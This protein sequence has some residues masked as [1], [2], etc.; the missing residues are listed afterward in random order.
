MRETTDDFRTSPVPPLHP[1]RFAR[2]SWQLTKDVVKEYSKDGVGD[3]AAAIT[4]W[5]IL[6]IPA[7]ALSLL[8][9]LTSL[10]AVFGESA[11]E[12]FRAEVTGFLDRTFTPN[13]T[14]ND[15]VDELLTTSNAGVATV[16]T[17]IA[18]FTASRAFAGLVRALDVAYEVPRGRPFWWGRIVGIGLALGTILLVVGAST[19]L[20]VLP[21][22]PGARVLGYLTLPVVLTIMVLWA[23]TLFHFGP[24]HKTPWRFDVPGAIF[25]VIG[26]VI[27]TQL[28]AIYVRSTA[29][30]NELRT[31]VG[32]VLL[33]LTLLYL[34]C[35]I[36]LV[37]AEINDV[38]AKRSGVIEELPPV[39]DRA[40]DIYNRLR[41]RVEG[42][43]PGD[44]HRN[45]SDGRDDSDDDGDD[46]DHAG[47]IGDDDRVP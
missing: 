31:T 12:R 13:A 44:E 17:L 30:A 25:T 9:T 22:L 19:Y 5:T 33:A 28:F 43:E 4:F 35:V 18:L 24:H 10:D 7:A 21:S 16:A 14:I 42:D 32:T 39:T 38:I 41:D 34:L 40:R 27:A 2:W 37:G 26:W 8:S 46:D 6:S 1:H 23:T 11:A 29:G 47:R 15:T 45:G 36:L 20:A 3:I